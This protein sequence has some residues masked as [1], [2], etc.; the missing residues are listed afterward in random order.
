LWEPTFQ[1]NILP[2][3]QGIKI[4]ERGT[5]VSTWQQTEP[6]IENTQ[7]YKNRRREGE[8]ATWEINREERGRV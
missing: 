1:R 3:L 5:S 2:P 8:W 7:I 4:T 6:P